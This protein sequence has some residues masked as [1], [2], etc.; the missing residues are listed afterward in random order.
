MFFNEWTERVREKRVPETTACWGDR[1][2]VD[3]RQTR[4]EHIIFLEQELWNYQSI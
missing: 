4:D 1:E 2:D 3:S